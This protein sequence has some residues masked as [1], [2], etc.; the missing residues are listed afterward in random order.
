MTEQPLRRQ[1]AEIYSHARVTYGPSTKLFAVAQGMEVLLDI[2]HGLEQP[3][4]EAARHA[5][6]LTYLMSATETRQTITTR[7][8]PESVLAGMFVSGK[9]EDPVRLHI[10][11]AAIDDFADSHRREDGIED[12]A[13]QCGQFAGTLVALITHHWPAARQCLIQPARGWCLLL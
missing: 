1:W 7:P 13:A 12:V 2:V 3:G 8:I 11:R 5:M 6:E 4:S 10:L 9:E